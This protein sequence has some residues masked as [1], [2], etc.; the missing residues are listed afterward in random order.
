[1]AKQLG[2]LSELFT[3]HYNKGN[4]A[5]NGCTPGTLIWTHEEGHRKF[6]KGESRIVNATQSLLSVFGIGGLTY[7]ALKGDLLALQVFA[8]TFV[9]IYCL[10]ELYAWMY[11]IKWFVS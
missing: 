6:A 2:K 8:L 4:D 5:I 11:S 7:F 9:V 1:M 10:D 3:A